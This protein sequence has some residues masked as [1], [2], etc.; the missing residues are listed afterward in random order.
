M[1][2]DLLQIDLLNSAG[3]VRYP[4]AATQ[5]SEVDATRQTSYH[6]VRRPDVGPADHGAANAAK[7]VAAARLAA[8][9][10]VE[11]AQRVRDGDQLIRAVAAV[12]QPHAHAACLRV[13]GHG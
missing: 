6:A 12:N 8:A 1:T 9:R 5:D 4:G 7:V 13:E 2:E 11:R 3:V 10:P